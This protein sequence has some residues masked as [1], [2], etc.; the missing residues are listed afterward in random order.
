MTERNYDDI[1]NLP[2]HVSTRHTPMPR[3]SRAAQFAPFA[4]LVGYDAA[5]MEEAR[6]TG[7]RVELSEERI[8]IINDR[9]FRLSQRLDEKPY[10]CITYFK[11]DA[12]KFGGEYVTLHGIVHNIDEIEGVIV[13]DD[14]KRIS[15]SDV[16][17]IEGDV[18]GKNP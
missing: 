15:V 5:V 17:S 2:R 11:N 7:R 3:E 1:I 14:K 6:I 9:I 10:V 16:L 18:F 8:S 4:A 13:M 12:R